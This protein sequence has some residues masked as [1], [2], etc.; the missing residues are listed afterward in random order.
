MILKTYKTAIKELKSMILASRYKAA[1]LAHKE[2]LLLYFAVGKLISDKSR[3]GEWGSGIL[4]TLSEDL[5]KELPGLR[6][7][8]S[9]NL[10]RMRLFYGPGKQNFNSSDMSANEKAG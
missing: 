3:E 4:G 10:K 5:Q 1:A 7:F 6:G 9:T 8:G 2:L